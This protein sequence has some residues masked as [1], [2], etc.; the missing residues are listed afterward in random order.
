[1]CVCVCVF[2]SF[3]SV[4]HF[5]NSQSY[6][7]ERF[8]YLFF[9]IIAQNTKKNKKKGEKCKFYTDE[10]FDDD[11]RDIGLE[12]GHFCEIPDKNF[13]IMLNFYQNC[14]IS[15]HYILHS[16]YETT[17]SFQ[18]QNGKCQNH[19]AVFFVVGCCLFFSGV[20]IV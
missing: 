17:Y 18:T 2:N 7:K 8:V 11:R 9:R 10:D 3:V 12:A 6:A 14:N 19:S 20:L 4:I 13:D 15:V 16:A 5:T 1:M